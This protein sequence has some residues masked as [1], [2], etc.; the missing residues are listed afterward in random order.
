MSWT[1]RK[2]KLTAMQRAALPAICEKWNRIGLSTAPANREEAERGAVELYQAFGHE[3]PKEFIWFNSFDEAVGLLHMGNGEWLPF[4][5]PQ[6]FSHLNWSLRNWPADFYRTPVIH[7]VD[8]V[9]QGSVFSQWSMEDLLRMVN[10]IHNRFELPICY[11]QDDTEWLARIDF[12]ANVVG[13]RYRNDL[14]G[15]MRIVSSCGFCWLGETKIGFFERPAVLH[16][17]DRHRP[18]SVDGPAIQYPGG[19]TMYA[20]HGVM[21]PQKYIDNPAEQIDLAEVLQEQNAEVR[22]AVISKVGFKR[23]LEAAKQKSRYLE[24][25]CPKC[26]E[27]FRIVKPKQPQREKGSPANVAM[28]LSEA[29]GNSLI[30]LTIG[31]RRRKG[32]RWDTNNR[33]PR[34]ERIRLLHLTWQDKTGSKET[35]IP[36]PL[37]KRQFGQDC[38][39]DVDDCEQVR[40]WTLGWGKDVEVVA[41]T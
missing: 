15:L 37:T 10:R 21:V 18:H 39:D 12:F 6:K 32:S 11:G 33:G 1:S 28:V 35:V 31:R 2:E 23:L 41:E 8:E 9:I 19:F 29:N 24:E 40:R 27:H 26:G 22:M 14:T 16:L 17:D 3:A 5:N 4:G 34:P 7:S 38:P 36:V 20:I 25:T 13:I 30:E